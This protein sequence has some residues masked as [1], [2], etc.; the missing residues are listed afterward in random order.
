[1]N[2]V[3][4]V[5]ISHQSLR[6]SSREWRVALIALVA[7]GSIVAGSLVTGASSPSSGTTFDATAVAGY[8]AAVAR[9]VRLNHLLEEGQAVLATAEQSRTRPSLIVDLRRDVSSLER[10]YATAIEAM[11]AASRTP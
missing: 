11:A 2:A 6:R 10:Q 3:E 5:L 1:M 4:S 9:V 7:L 8:D